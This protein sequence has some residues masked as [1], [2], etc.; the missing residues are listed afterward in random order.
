MADTRGTGVAAIAAGVL[1]AYAGV[2]GYSVG[3]TI[4]SLVTGKSPQNQAQVSPV[5]TP[6]GSAAAGSQD[7]GT[8]SPGGSGG[9]PSQNKALGQ[10][11][12]AAAPYNWTGAQWTALN[13]IVEAESGWS[14][15]V[16]NS[17]S[18]A[19]GI[20]QNINGWSSDYQKGNARQQIAWLLNYIQQRYGTPV[21][22]WAFHKKNGWY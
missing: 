3:T 20:A 19:S 17:S 12:A 5:G 1:L 15:T 2:K 18:T 16:V 13:D 14:S 4:K 11:M 22:A 6:T 10:Q 9:T 7:T 21:M 8:S